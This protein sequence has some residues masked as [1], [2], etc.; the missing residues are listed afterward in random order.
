MMEALYVDGELDGV[1]SKFREDGT[2]LH[3]V[4]WEKGRLVQEEHFNEKG[5]RQ[6]KLI[7]KQ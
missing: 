6:V 3:K 7:P 1:E 5:D 2:L 4:Y